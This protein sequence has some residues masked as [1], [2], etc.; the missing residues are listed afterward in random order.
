MDTATFGPVAETSDAAISSTARIGGC[1]N[2]LASRETS[3]LHDP[4]QR[5][6]L[7][8]KDH[9]MHGEAQHV[10]APRSDGGGAGEDEDQRMDGRGKGSGGD[11]PQV[12]PGET[13]ASHVGIRKSHG[14]DPRARLADVMIRIVAG[15]PRCRLDD[16][17]ATANARRSTLPAKS[18]GYPA[19]GFTPGGRRSGVV[20]GG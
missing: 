4:M 5:R 11:G 8:E 3:H 20:T 12:G 1:K 18:S 16:R 6:C 19:A 14:I 17:R 2:D 7:D 9:Q 13:F 15:H 10:A